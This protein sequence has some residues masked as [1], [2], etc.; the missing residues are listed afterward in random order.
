MQVAARSRP[1]RACLGTPPPPL[2]AAHGYGRDR[3]L[4]LLTPP[5]SPLLSPLHLPAL[6]VRAERDPSKRIVITGM[7]IASV[8]GNDVDKFYEK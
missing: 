1:T 5:L 8:F 3:A 2:G 4:S 7:G 6:V